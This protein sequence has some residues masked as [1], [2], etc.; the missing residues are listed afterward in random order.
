MTRTNSVMYL[1]GISDQVIH[2]RFD[3]SLYRQFSGISMGMKFYPPA[4]NLLAC[5]YDR[6]FKVSLST[7]YKWTIHV[8]YAFIYV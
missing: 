5:C 7:L 4:A 3:S 1:F 2:I 6:A 8:V